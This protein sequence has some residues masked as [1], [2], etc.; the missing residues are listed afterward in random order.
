MIFPFSGYHR[1]T[2]DTRWPRTSEQ[3]KRMRLCRERRLESV[4]QLCAVSQRC[5]LGTCVSSHREVCS[6]PLCCLT[7]KSAQH[8]CV[9]SQRSLLSTFVLSHKEVCSAPLCCLT[10]KSAQHL[11]VVSQ[12]SLLSTF[13]LS[14]KEVCSAPLCSLTK[15][16]AQHLSFSCLTAYIQSGPPLQPKK[17][18]LLIINFHELRYVTEVSI[19]GIAAFTK[20]NHS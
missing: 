5:L 6:A 13:V 14:H 3:P 9:L 15:K 4:Q 19:S 17:I 18:L 2:V 16:S 10:K 20:K 1:T 11:C 8:L 7:E 12:R